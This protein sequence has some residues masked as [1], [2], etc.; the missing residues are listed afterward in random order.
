MKWQ[1]DG[2][3]KQHPPWIDNNPT[4][5][6]AVGQVL[7]VMK[8]PERPQLI[9][10]YRG[11]FEFPVN[12]S[13]LR[14]L[15]GNELSSLPEEKKNEKQKNVSSL[16]VISDLQHLLKKFSDLIAC[17]TVCMCW[18][19]LFHWASSGYAIRAEFWAVLN[20]TWALRWPQTW[21]SGPLHH[22]RHGWRPGWPPLLPCRLAMLGQAQ[23]PGTDEK[24]ERKDNEILHIKHW[25]TLSYLARANECNFENPAAQVKCVPCELNRWETKPLLYPPRV[26]VGDE[27]SEWTK[28]RR[29]RGMTR[30]QRGDT[31][32]RRKRKTAGERNEKRSGVIGDKRWVICILMLSDCLYGQCQT[33]RGIVRVKIP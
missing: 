17:Q 15:V 18:P 14:H 20:R 10:E 22:S 3:H 29:S 25:L 9:L 27:H 24:K 7:L 32:D 11:L 16:H 12:I 30:D 31:T 6:S 4:V 28:E 21:Q 8:T 23:Q 13:T 2:L 26:I 1:G 5:Y 19:L 33:E